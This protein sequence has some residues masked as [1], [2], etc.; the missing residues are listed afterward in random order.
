MTFSLKYQLPFINQYT[1]FDLDFCVQDL[2]GEANNFNA[3]Y[4][5]MDSEFTAFPVCIAAGYVQ[6]DSTNDRMNGP[7]A[8]IEY[9]P[10][11]FV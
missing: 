8:A 2:G 9:Q 3:Y 1:G 5:V 7:F 11:S 4:A 6:S 10:L